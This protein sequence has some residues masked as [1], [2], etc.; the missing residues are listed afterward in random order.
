MKQISQN[1]RSGHITVESV[2]S[3]TITK[4]HLLVQTHY[5]VISP[6]TERASVQSRS[7]SLLDRARKNPDLV[8]KVVEQM[9]GVI[10]AIAKAEDLAM[11]VEKTA[12]S[13]LYARDGADLTD[14]VIQRM[15]GQK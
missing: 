13:V 11:V 5:S 3:P 4:G 8:R 7:S 2:P 9:R 6:G 15:D 14:R 1:I 10:A 12:T